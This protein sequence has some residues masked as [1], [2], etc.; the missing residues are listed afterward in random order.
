MF[1]IEDIPT[2]KPFD[3]AQR[4]TIGCGGKATQAYY[5]RS[6][7]ELCA[8]LKHLPKP[9]LILGNLSN[10]LPP[11]T[12]MDKIVACTKRMTAIYRDGDFGHVRLHRRHLARA[13][14]GFGAVF[15]AYR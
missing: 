2:E 4:S 3:F 12:D 6:E 1:V 7:A 9:P 8:L 5:P 14:D 13:L 11:D 10:V 15:G